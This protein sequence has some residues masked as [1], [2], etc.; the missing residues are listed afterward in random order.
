M[1]R[2]EFPVAGVA[3]F[4][5]IVFGEDAGASWDCAAITPGMELALTGLANVSPPEREPTT[6]PLDG[7]DDVTAAGGV[8]LM[9]ESGR[10]GRV[11]LQSTSGEEELVAAL[12]VGVEFV[13]VEFAAETLVLEGRLEAESRLGRVLDEFR[14]TSAHR[15][16][17]RTHM[18][19][20]T[21]VFDHRRAKAAGVGIGTGPML[22]GHA[23]SNC[24]IAAEFTIT[25]S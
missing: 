23:V 5:G 18:A 2:I 15:A 24:S 22:I 8:L 21:K 6:G 7:L 17:T 1:D 13:G 9:T 25:G 16:S 19:A 11:R 14:R 4:P 20:L 3:E 12:F 10:Y